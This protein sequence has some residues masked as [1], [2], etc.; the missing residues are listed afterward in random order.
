MEMPT[1]Q[2]RLSAHGVGGDAHEQEYCKR[3]TSP[4]LHF[5]LA[6]PLLSAL[7]LTRSMMR[8]ASE[9]KSL[10]PVCFYR[11]KNLRM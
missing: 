8:T 11:V 3:S 9:C 1:L 5:S 2:N 7:A 10:H 4:H 6:A